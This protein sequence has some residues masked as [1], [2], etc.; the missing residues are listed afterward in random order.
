MGAM[1]ANIDFPS[2]KWKWESSFPSIHV[3]CKMLWEN[4]Y[5][6]DYDQICNKIFPTLYQI[7]SCEEAPCLSPKG[8]AIV[9]EYADWY[10]TPIAVYI[11]IVGSTKPPHW[12]PHFVPN[13]LLFQEISYHTFVNGVVAS[14]HKHKKGLWPLFP[15]MTLVCKIENFK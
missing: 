4:K 10:M 13:S 7:L 2:L 11:R 9:M 12:L 5:K 15:L 3:Y 14:L 8:Q 1:C 6:E